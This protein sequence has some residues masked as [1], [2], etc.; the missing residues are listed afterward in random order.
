[1]SA[2][3]LF[4]KLS[5]SNKIA[6]VSFVLSV[7]LVFVSFPF[8]SK[9]TEVYAEQGKVEIFNSGT[10]PDEKYTFSPPVNQSRSQLP[11]TVQYIYVPA[12]GWEY[13]YAKS[14]YCNSFMIYKS[15]KL[16]ESY[17][18]YFNTVEECVDAVQKKKDIYSQYSTE[19]SKLDSYATISIVL[20]IAFFGLTLV[21]LGLKLLLAMWKILVRE[22]VSAVQQGKNK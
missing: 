3:S 16:S 17:P 14:E 21:I 8:S 18:N 2:K 20:A 4:M 7:V 9:R 10:R 22:T 13:A 5:L 1:M 12:K 19:A 6:A 11:D 15:S